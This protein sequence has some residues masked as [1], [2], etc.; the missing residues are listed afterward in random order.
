MA[1]NKRYKEDIENWRDRRKRHPKIYFKNVRNKEKHG[2]VNS[3]KSLRY[4]ERAMESVK[5]RNSIK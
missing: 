1:K 5:G 2:A 4:D 3:L